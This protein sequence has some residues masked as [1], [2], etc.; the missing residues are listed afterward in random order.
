M[1][2]RILR[3]ANVKDNLYVALQIFRGTVVWKC[4]NLFTASARYII[5]IS[6]LQKKYESSFIQRVRAVTM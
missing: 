2:R 3:R 6:V 1:M 4:F 5:Y